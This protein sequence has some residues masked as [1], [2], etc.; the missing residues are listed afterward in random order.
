MELREPNYHEFTHLPQWTQAIWIG[1]SGDGKLANEFD[2]YKWSGDKPPPAIGE[3]IKVL[4]NGLGK[5]T[6]LRYFAEYGWL[7][8]IVQFDK[9]PKWYRQ[10][11][12]DKPG[13]VFGI[14]L[15]P[16]SKLL[17]QPAKESR[18]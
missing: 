8:M 5:G 7:G 2:P 12:G 13:H 16:R 9:P 1:K 17:P 14:D 18:V 4:C 11:N 3:K 10:Q 6:V 15:N